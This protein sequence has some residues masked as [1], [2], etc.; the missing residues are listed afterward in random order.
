MAEW[1]TAPLLASLNGVSF[2][3]LTIS[4]QLDRALVLHAYPDNDGADLEDTGAQPREVRVEG[5]L[6][7]AGWLT[8]L[9]ALEAACGQAGRHTL[10]HPQLGTLT[11]RV[12]GLSHSHNADE[13][14]IARIS[15]TFTVGTVR[16]FS[17]ATGTSV[18]S[19]AVAV[20]SAGADVTAA[21]AGL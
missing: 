9:R 15:L 5:T 4:D 18:T 19:A 21:L 11:G 10:V 2:N 7:G 16:D 13:P 12:R 8:Q 14:S 17:F 6:S 3:V 20:E 1:M